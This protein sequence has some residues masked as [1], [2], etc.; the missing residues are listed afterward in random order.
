MKKTL[1]ASGVVLLLLTACPDPNDPNKPSVA[2][3]TPA[4]DA[5]VSNTIPIQLDAT[6]NQTV[7]RVEVFVRGRGS[8]QQGLSIGSAVSSPYV[9]QWD[10]TGV[11]NNT[12]LELVARA[13]DI[14]GN[15][16][17][18]TPIRIKTQ[19]ANLPSLTLLSGYSLPPKPAQF[20]GAA[21]ASGT[22]G[23]VVPEHTARVLESLQAPKNL[24][25]LRANASGAAVR[26]LALTRDLALEWEWSPFQSVG[27]I[28]GADGYGV[29][30]SKL[31]VAGAYQRLLNQ[32]ATASGAQ[33]FSK[34]FP[35]AR[36][37]D[38]YFGCVT[39]IVDN[40]SRETPCSN[41]DAAKFPPEQDV[42]SPQDGAT[43]SDGRPT[44][45]WTA[46]PNAIGYLYLLY[47]RNPW[48]ANAKIVWRNTP[49]T[50][51]TDKLL[52]AY[53][54][55]LAPLAKGTYYWWVAGVS[56][57]A[58]GKADGFSF[59]DPRSLIVP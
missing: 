50:Q 29:F 58:F 16:G 37:G 41:A 57:D 27:S 14:A 23:A 43:V 59:S 22:F 48:D 6:D 47:D 44:L 34:I 1:F 53:P 26:P 15:E 20:A 31:D 35:E 19:N 9:V 28:T 49:A 5:T 33:K 11:P 54:N 52:A 45:T 2:I 24:S 8:T 25:A 32:Q 38:V 51:T 55:N 17:S 12:E 36:V 46:T 3:T 7:A 4:S 42:A 10:T 18:S 39:A 40:R 30:L 13:Y 56:F 21:R